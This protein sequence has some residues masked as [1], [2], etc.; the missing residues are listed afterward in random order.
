[1]EKSGKIGKIR[2]KI[3]KNRPNCEKNEPLSHAAADDFNTDHA[4]GEE[5]LWERQ[6]ETH[7]RSFKLINE[8]LTDLFGIFEKNWRLR[9][10]T[11]QQFYL[12]ILQA[13]TRKRSQTMILIKSLRP[14]NETRGNDE[15]VCR[16]GTWNVD[17]DMMEKCDKTKTLKKTL[18]TGKTGN[19]LSQKLTVSGLDRIRLSLNE[20][21]TLRQ[22]TNRFS[23]C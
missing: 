10:V 17:V 19:R 12:L 15:S 9:K 11:V 21:D 20:P 16:K 1:V 3:E 4:P 18:R 8:D 23:Y 14:C 2:P 13:I 7:N 6:G 22:M 5:G